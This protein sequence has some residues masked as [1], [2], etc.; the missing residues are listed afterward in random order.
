VR[1]LVLKY[2]TNIHFVRGT[3]TGLVAS[4][5]GSRLIGAHV[6]AEQGAKTDESMHKLVF[7]VDCTG[8]A[9]GAVKWLPRANPAWSPGTSD[10]YDP[11]G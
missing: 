3:V 4:A 8:P 11:A 7:F 6:R 10:Q 9:C 2:C 5:D 1:R